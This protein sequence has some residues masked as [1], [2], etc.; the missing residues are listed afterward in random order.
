MVEGIEAGTKLLLIDED[1]SATNFMIRDE[2]MQRVI[3]REMEPIT[4]FIERIRE[5]YEEYDISTVIVAGSSGSLFPY[6]GQRDSDG[7]VYAERHYSFCK[8][9]SRDISGDQCTG[10]G[11]KATGFQKMSDSKPGIK[12]RRPCENES[13]GMRGG[14]HQPGHD[15]SSLCRTIDR[16]RAAY[17]TWVLYPLCTEADHRWKKDAARDCRGTGKDTGQRRAGGSEWKWFKCAMYGNAEETGD[18]RLL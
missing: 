7:P 14:V 3:H 1:T 5:L 10:S 17:Y 12:K 15:R 9:R 8:E 4:P 16:Q 11:C 6:S 2:L 13:D 18:F